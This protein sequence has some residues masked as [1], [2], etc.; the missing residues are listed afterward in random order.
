MD[1]GSDTFWGPNIRNKSKILCVI[2]GLRV[3]FGQKNTE[4]YEH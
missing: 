2:N 3:L 4:H 1:L